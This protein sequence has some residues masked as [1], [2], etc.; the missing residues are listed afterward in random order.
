MM[1]RARLKFIKHFIYIFMMKYIKENV[2]IILVKTSLILLRNWFQDE[3]TGD[4]FKLYVYTGV[5][6]WSI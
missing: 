1:L 3:V 4:I 2:A 6:R 5:E